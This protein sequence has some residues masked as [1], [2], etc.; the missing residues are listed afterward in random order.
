MAFGA[1]IVISVISTII[2]VPISA[3]LLM[4]STKIFKLKDTSYGTAF[5]VALIVGIVGLIFS[6]IG[7][8][9][10]ALA[11][12]MAIVSF[13][14]SIILGLWLINAKYKIDWSK[15]ALVWLIWFVLSIIAAFIIGLIVAAIAVAIGISM[16]AGAG[17]I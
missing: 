16:M 9:S 3:L 13:I 14:V 2:M 5:M 7:S 4:L 6:I 1:Q 15:T 10:I 17:S 11:M 8:V 12:I